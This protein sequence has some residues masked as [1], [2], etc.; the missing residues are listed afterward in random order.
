MYTEMRQVAYKVL[1]TIGWNIQV[2]KEI[3]RRN[4]EII[5]ITYDKYKI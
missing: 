2:E 4:L 3:V 5:I 1:V